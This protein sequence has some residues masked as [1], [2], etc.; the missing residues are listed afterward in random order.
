[1]VSLVKVLAYVFPTSE[2]QSKFLKMSLLQL[3][4]LENCSYLEIATIKSKNV[5]EM[6]LHSLLFCSSVFL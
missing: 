5:C 2:L 3:S 4:H 1:M 6:E